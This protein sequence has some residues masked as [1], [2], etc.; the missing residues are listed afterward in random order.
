MNKATP[1]NED[2]LEAILNIEV[3]NKCRSVDVAKYLN[4]SKPAVVLA[5]NNMIEKGYI[6]KESYGDIILTD[7]GREI[8]TSTVNKHN[9]LKEWLMSIGVP[10]GI[11]DKESCE[12]EHIISDVTMNCIQKVLE[13]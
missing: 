4:V 8:A 7:L 1:S 9:I 5:T 6:T 3:D 10:E 13:K 2:Y 11:A 12:I